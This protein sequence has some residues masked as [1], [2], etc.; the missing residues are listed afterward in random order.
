MLVVQC[1][2]YERTPVTSDTWKYEQIN[3]ASWH[4][5]GRL[6]T[7]HP[8]QVGDLLSLWDQ[9]RREGGSFRVMDRQW[10]HPTYGSMDW[11]HGQQMQAE[12]STLTVIV[13]RDMGIF[14]REVTENGQ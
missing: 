7:H 1:C 10:H 5:D 9:T 8:P 14:Y 12:A 13:E 2:F 3:V 11:R 4:G 6:R